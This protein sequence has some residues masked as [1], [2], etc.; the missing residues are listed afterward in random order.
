MKSLSIWSAAMAC[1][2]VLMS[3][4]TTTTGTGY[5]TTRNGVSSPVRLAWMS[6]DS[7]S[8]TLTATLDNGESF[9]G[10]YFQITSDLR[11]ERLAPL[12]DGWYGP[13]G[14][15]PYWSAYAG[16]NFYTQYSGRVVA[17]LLGTKGEHMRCRFRLMHP[18]E[19]MSGGGSGECQLPGS[20]S[21]DAVLSPSR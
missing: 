17:N 20:L 19:G 11:V 9:Q 21:I 14:G 7:I 5:G 1:G 12:W 2:A 18:A 8:G 10:P 6:T 16:P 13:L 4:C 15:W 3:S